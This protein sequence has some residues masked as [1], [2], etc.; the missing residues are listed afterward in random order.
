MNILV[1]LNYKNELVVVDLL[2]N[3]I[4]QKKQM[5]QEINNIIAS[6]FH[7]LAIMYGEAGLIRVV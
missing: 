1:M 3:R 7:P 6:K 4:I 5:H 2:S